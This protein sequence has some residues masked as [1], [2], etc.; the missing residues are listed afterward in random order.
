MKST[1]KQSKT[2]IARKPAL[3]S[4]IINALRK[5]N[6]SKV[7]NLEEVKRAKDYSQ[8]LDAT[9][10]KMKTI[11]YLD[12]LHAYYVYAQNTM[13]ILSEQLSELPALQKLNNICVDAYEE[14]TPQGP[15]ISPL[16]KSYFSCWS[17][18]DLNVG[19]HKESFGYIVTEVCKELK[20]DKGLISAFEIM[21]SSR[22]GLYIHEGN[23]GRYV[24]LR[25]LVTGKSIQAIVPSG[26][27]GRP[28]EIWLARILPPTLPDFGVDY[29]LVFTTPYVIGTMMGRRIDLRG[30]IQGWNDYFDRTLN[31]IKADNPVK[32]YEQLMKYGLNRHY[33]NEYIFEGYFSHNKESVVLAGFPDIPLSRPHS[34][35]NQ[36]L[37]GG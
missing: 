33:W 14:Y 37:V 32:A 22:M 15:P 26:Y 5:E 21:T 6:Q 31:I 7:V 3:T 23:S 25:E 12:P 8:E 30:D 24:F 2:S 11:D 1:R 34:R 4:K 16:T 35:E 10:S 13:S 17:L 20:V 18:F 9:I 36:A 27:K 19:I 28:D 29:S